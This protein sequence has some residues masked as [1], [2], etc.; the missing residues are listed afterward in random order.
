MTG[1][2]LKK[3][4]GCLVDSTVLHISRFLHRK[5]AVQPV[6]VAELFQSLHN[7]LPKGHDVAS[8][9][10]STLTTCTLVYSCCTSMLARP[11]LPVA[12]RFLSCSTTAVL[13]VYLR[14]ALSR[15]GQDK[16][17]WHPAKLQSIQHSSNPPTRAK[18]FNHST[19]VLYDTILKAARQGLHCNSSQ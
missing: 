15:E 11:H 7:S 17:W 13:K 14:T 16:R 10:P 9:S 2:L 5:T 3:H 8:S 12:R 6:D 18:L 4:G 19:S 1:V